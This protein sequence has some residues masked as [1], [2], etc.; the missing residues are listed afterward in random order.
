MWKLN[1]VWDYP[2][3]RSGGSLDI[4]GW[5]KS[6]LS[7]LQWAQNRGF[8]KKQG[9]HWIWDLGH[10]AS[11][12][13]P[14]MC[15]A[16]RTVDLP[17]LVALKVMDTRIKRGSLYFPFNHHATK[18]II[19]Q[20]SNKVMFNTIKKRQCR[21]PRKT[22]SNKSNERISGPFGRN[23]SHPLAGPQAKVLEGGQTFPQAWHRP[24]VWH[25]TGLCTCVFCLGF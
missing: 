15:R 11:R 21:D 12:S 14:G 10:L 25:V 6:N 2:Y 7:W 3:C 5:C 19:F 17:W 20:R 24:N 13:T 23:P 18:E 4:P 8:G 1:L 16:H 9:K 22:M